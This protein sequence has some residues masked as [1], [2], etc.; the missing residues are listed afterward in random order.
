M[1]YHKIRWI[2]LLLWLMSFVAYASPNKMLK[3]EV[4]NMPQEAR[5]YVT[6]TAPVTPR[7]FSLA[8]PYRIILDFDQTQPADGVRLVSFKNQRIS[9]IRYGL[10]RPD[11]LRVVIDLPRES[12]YKIMPSG[13]ERRFRLDVLGA[14]T[15]VQ[16]DDQAAVSQ[17]KR[18]GSFNQKKENEYIK[19]AMFPHQ[20][21]PITIVVDAGHGGKDPGAIG[22]SGVKEKDVVLAISKRLVDLINQHPNMHAVMTRDGD[23]FV[24]LRKRLQMARQSKADLFVAIHADSYL[25]TKANGASV[26]ALSQ[27]GASSVAARWLAERDNHSELGGVDLGELEDQSYI[28]RSVMIDLAQTATNKASMRMGSTLLDALENVTSLHYARVEKAPF[29]VLKSPDIPSV[30]VETGFI[31]NSKEERRLSDRSYQNK[32][33][34]ALYDGIRFYHQKYL[35]KE[36]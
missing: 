19:A 27:H 29:M 22:E 13:S 1:M 24:S 5:I 15:V 28:L 2:G 21:R 16:H 30:L 4:F 10:P 6:L 9:G 17:V 33:A 25:N 8:K 31:S 35:S 23:Y 34:T 14:S 32:I 20:S 7:V 11:A 12:H 18:A 36:V 26:Y 3:L